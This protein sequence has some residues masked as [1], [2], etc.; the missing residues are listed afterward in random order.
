MAN[1][2]L[3]ANNHPL[4]TS[5]DIV[6]ETQVLAWS[7]HADFKYLFETGV[8]KPLG[9][10]LA[11][12]RTEKPTVPILIA[13]NN[14]LAEALQDRTEEL[15]RAKLRIGAL[16]DEANR[17]EGERK[18]FEAQKREFLESHAEAVGQRDGL[19]EKAERLTAEVDSLKA[20]LAAAESNDVAVAPVAT[21]ATVDPMN[22]A[23][24]TPAPGTVP[25]VAPFPAPNPGSPK[26]S[27]KVKPV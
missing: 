8:L 3:L 27:G 23:E 9:N 2:K 22:P 15:H 17:Y 5:G 7:P 6:T 26:P 24:K 10:A 21:G 19:D 1:F 16:E 12:L 4:G 18:E 13:E 20:K 25:G 11:E 14:E